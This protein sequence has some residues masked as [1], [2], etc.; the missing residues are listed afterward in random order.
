MA[1]TIAIANQKGGVGKT[2]TCVNLAAFFAAFGKHVL[3]IDNDPQGNA[4]SGLGIEK[5]KVKK[6]VYSLIVGDC[7]AKEAIV[8]T[9]VDGLDIIPSNIDLAGAEVELVGLEN[10]ENSLKRAIASIKNDYD[11]IFIDCPPFIGL[12]TLNALTAADSI[13]IPMQGEYFALEGLSQLMNTI[14]LTKK[15]LN[16]SLEIEGVVVTMFNSR[17]NLVNSVAEEITRYFGKKAFS[18]RIPRSVRLAEAPSFG[19]PITQFDPT[20]TGGIAYKNLAEEMLNRNRDPFTPIK[21]LSAL[22]KKNQ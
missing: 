17:T 1:K 3:V 14:K 18:T 13:L 7:T 16:P 2:T 9:G 10:R 6:S 19:L 12:L 4:S 5:H 22:K 8:G 15:I 20:S 21:N 11:Y